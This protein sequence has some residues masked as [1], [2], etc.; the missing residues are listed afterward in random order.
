MFLL[1]PIVLVGGAIAYIVGC[2]VGLRRA[3]FQAKRQPPKQ[4]APHQ[5]GPGA[6]VRTGGARVGRF[7]ATVPLVRMTVDQDW[8]N[9][10]GP[11]IS[12]W[13]ARTDVSRVRRIRVFPILGDGVMFDSADGRFDGVV[14]WAV[15]ASEAVACMASLGWDTQ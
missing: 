12:V 9:L 10:S 1:L 6:L 11:L 4:S 13:L 2:W 14:F 3:G 7:N 15:A 5:F 8:A